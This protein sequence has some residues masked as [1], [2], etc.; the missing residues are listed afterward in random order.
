MQRGGVRILLVLLIGDFYCEVKLATDRMGLMTQCLKWK[1]VLKPP[2]GFHMNLMLKINTKM[3][4]TNHTLASRLSPEGAREAPSTFQDP[5]ASLSWVFDKPCMLVGIDTSHAEPGA[6]KKSMAAVVGSINGQASQYAAHISAQASRVE[7]VEALTDA[8]SALLATFKSK[9]HGRLPE[10]IIVYRDGVGDGQFEEVLAKELPCIREALALH[11]DLICKIAFVVCQKRHHTRLVYED[12]PG[13]YVN[14]CPGLCVDGS[15]R[16]KSIT[17]AVYNEFYL[18][19]HT[20][21]QG[22]AKSCKYSL[23]HDDIGMKIAELELLTYWSCYLYTRCN[24]SVSLATP[25]YYAHWASRRAKYLFT[26]GAD[27]RDLRDI[28]QKWSEEG[29]DSTMFFV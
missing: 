12:A 10:H 21:I 17:S 8:M 14:V 18:N 1:N 6:N 7:V 5:P 11:G 16:E 24:R 25:C 22:T 3:G 13:N 20:A 23:L 26:A 15:G 2:R 4:G 19:S 29:R 9:N 28:S 27:E